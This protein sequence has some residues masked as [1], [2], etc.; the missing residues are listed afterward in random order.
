MDYPIYFQDGKLCADL[1]DYDNNLY[2]EC[3]SEHETK[4]IYIEMKNYYENETKVYSF[5]NSNIKR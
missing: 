1:Y 4:N 3:L 5:K 2:G